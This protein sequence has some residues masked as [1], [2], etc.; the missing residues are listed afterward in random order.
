M[1]YIKK[2]INGIEMKIEVYSDEFY[3]VCPKCGKEHNLDED[4]LQGILA[5]NVDFAGTSLFCKEC[6]DLKLDTNKKMDYR[7]A[8]ENQIRTLQQAQERIMKS[9]PL[10]GVVPIANEIQNI[11]KC[12]NDHKYQF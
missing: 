7:E 9:G 6:S 2:E 10:Q 3:S 4:T 1:I 5:D 8:L 12:L 11:V